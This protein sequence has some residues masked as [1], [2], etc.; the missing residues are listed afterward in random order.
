[1]K[2]T[3]DH[4][5]IRIITFVVL[6]NLFS[7][8]LSSQTKPSIAFSDSLVCLE[9]SGRIQRGETNDDKYIKVVLIHYNTPVDSV[10]IK[11]NR[12]FKFKLVKDAYYA[13]KIYRKGYAPRLISICTN[14]P[15]EVFNDRIL[16]FYFKT[17]LVSEQ[18]YAGFNKETRDFPIAIVAFN[19]SKKGFY[20]NE[21]YTENIKKSLLQSDKDYLADSKNNLHM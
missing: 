12:S 14:V 20:H 4:L 10:Q 11:E 13:I 6:L 8:A 15:E 1:M 2:T 9:I 5:K 18:E 21:I 19:R 7:L 16:R 17:G 3:F